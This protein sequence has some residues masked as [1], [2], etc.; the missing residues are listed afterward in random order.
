MTARET[1]IMNLRVEHENDIRT[2]RLG[3]KEVEENCL[4]L[5]E[6]NKSLE[7][8]VHVLQKEKELNEENDDKSRTSAK[9]LSLRLQ[10][11]EDRI[12]QQIGDIVTLN[13]KIAKKDKELENWE[14]KFKAL[15]K[16]SDQVIQNKIENLEIQM[17]QELQAE[18]KKYYE[19]SQV[20]KRELEEKSLAM[21]RKTEEVKQLDI[22]RK[23]LVIEN[24]K[25]NRNI[26][27]LTNDLKLVKVEVINLEK[28]Y[29]SKLNNAKNEMEKETQSQLV[30]LYF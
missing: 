14:M 12:M 28:G 13:E 17:K 29:E 7:E 5:L 21:K 3:Y 25:L 10:E 30:N 23:V 6:K 8:R 9:N 22:E 15:E 26:E 24:N 2:I 27:E 20:I 19:E 16:T 11:A 4:A 18:K 1:E